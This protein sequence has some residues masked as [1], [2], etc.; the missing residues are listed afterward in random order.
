MLALAIVTDLAS[1]KYRMIKIS[2]Q[3]DAVVVGAGVAGGCIAALLVDRGWTVL[4][5]EKSTWPR[6]TTC[7]GCLSA[8]AIEMLRD[9]KMDSA[10]KDARPTHSVVWQRSE[11]TFEHEIPPGA[12]VL[13]CKLDSAIAAEA[14]LR[15]VQFLPDSCAT[16]LPATTCN[17][18]FRSVK[19][20]MRD[21]TSEIRTR[22]V[23]ACDGVGGS[24]LK[25]E[26]WATWTISPD[27][28]MGVSATYQCQ[29]S[30]P[31]SNRIH[32]CVGRHGYVGR[33]RTDDCTEHLAAAL[34][35]ASC[36]R[37]GGPLKLIGQILHSCQQPIPTGLATARLYGEGKLT[38]HRKTLGG[39]R[40]LALGDACGYVEPITGEGMTHAL[41][42]S[43]ELNRLL[44]TSAIDWPVDL[45]ER[46]RTR[47]W[48]VIGRQ[49]RYCRAIKSVA[50]H[51]M[52][53]GAGI[54]M[55]NAMPALARRVAR[56]ICQPSIMRLK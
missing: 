9:I 27:A 11:N 6:E 7:G 16:L 53:A 28:L 54:F 3:W 21:Q 35:P 36:R 24:F 39:H 4:L 19:L 26:S 56:A 14:V 29:S 50:H 31:L 46:W 41:R 45:P 52:L 51:P 1:G 25:H 47:H 44:P 15:G 22:V 40:V 13:R 20:Q 2:D 30:E 42:G 5:V 34:E 38:R 33:V 32:M 48:Q 23:I 10:L 12:A 17:D 49:Q 37:L 43:L 8:A 18:P 55:G